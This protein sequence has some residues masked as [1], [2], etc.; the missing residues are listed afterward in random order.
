M[1]ILPLLFPILK[2]FTI[3]A[4]PAPLFYL[5]RS[6][7]SLPAS[8][9]R[10][11]H[12][13]PVISLL[14]IAI[15]L[16][17]AF[18]YLT[19]AILGGSENIFYLTNARFITPSNVLSARLSKVRPLTQ[20]DGVLISRL[21]TSL[22]DRISYT[23][24]GPEPLIHCTWCLTASDD[25]GTHGDAAMYLIFSLPQILSPYLVHAFILG[26]TTTPFLAR[27]YVTRNMRVYVSY[28]LGLAMATE[29]W[30]LITFDGTKN[31]SATTLREVTW[32]HWDLF[33]F[34]YGSLA[35][36]SVLH[37]LVIYLLDTGAVVLPAAMEDRLFQLAAM[38]ENVYQRMRFTRILKGVVMKR[39]A[40]RT[41]V[42]QYWDTQRGNE[43]TV[44]EE[45]KSLWEPDARKWVDGMI[46][47]EEE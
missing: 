20:E 19:A 9:H 35:F 13:L 29:V 44:P 34:R 25:G 23:I 41:K 32:L 45:V 14:S 26:L 37:A 16:L 6:W 47:F 31:A 38:E 36:T 28:L 22:A 30:I 27:G 24:Y 3:L 21:S 2:Q 42:V 39:S 5:Y 4:G 11:R 40:W 7:Q 8:V 15:L 12:P 10:S 18:V 43:P 1:G 33:S 17:A 46:K